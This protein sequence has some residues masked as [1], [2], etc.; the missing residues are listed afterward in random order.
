MVWVALMGAIGCDDCSAH[1]CNSQRNIKAI[2]QDQ[3]HP[4]VQSQFPHD[5]PIFQ[6]DNALT[7]TTKEKILKMM[8][9]HIP[10]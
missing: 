2:L 9:G 4:T 10:Y 3:G 5:V 6:D 1:T 8:R 7:R